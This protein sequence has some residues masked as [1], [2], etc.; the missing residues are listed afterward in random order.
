MGPGEHVAEQE[1]RLSMRMYFRDELLLLLERAG[2]S[3]VEVFGGYSG[4]APTPD[5]DVLVYLARR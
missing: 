3:G 2:F 4:E 1:H 5:C